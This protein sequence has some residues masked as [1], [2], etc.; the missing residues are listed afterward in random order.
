MYIQSLDIENIKCLKK[1][2]IELSPDALEGWHVVIGDNGAGKSTLAKS[3]A[4]CLIGAV[5]AS[6]LR[7]NWSKWV[8]Q[9]CKKGHIKIRLNPGASN[10]NA[11]D[12]IGVCFVKEGESTRL[13]ELAETD[14]GEKPDLFC[15]SYGPFRRFSGGDN[16]IEILQS[17][18]PRSSPHISL[19]Q[20]NIALTEC[21][22][23]LQKIHYRELDKKEKRRLLPALKKFINEGRLL[24]NGAV[25]KKV[26]SDGVIF[27]DANGSDLD[28]GELSDGY[29][30]ILSLTLDLI[31]QMVRFFSWREISDNL[32]KGFIDLPGVVIIDEIDSHLHP[33]WQK[34]IGYWLTTYFPKIQ[35]IATTHSPIVCHAAEKGSIWRLA[36]PGTE[37]KSGKV[38]GTDRKRLLFGN[39][40]EALDTELFGRD[41][42]RSDSSRKKLERMA[43]LN[44]L[45]IEGETSE[46]NEKE[47][48]ELRAIM[49]TSINVGIRRGG[50]E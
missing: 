3:I 6:G 23:W 48:R 44:K 37:Q 16:D 38:E 13:H 5:D 40:I 28:I 36:S 19:F 11:G 25:L 46:E 34:R 24:P 30:S 2:K 41:V 29:R 39:I 42:I 26:G 9:N 31:H 18:H 1:Y 8:R 50:G 22:R 12:D 21:L 45:S 7:E 15:A 47:L 32:M 4:L 10:D 49:P 43:K 27:K 20:E 14:G 35:F 17:S 33:S